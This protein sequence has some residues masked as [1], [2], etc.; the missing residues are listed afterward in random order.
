MIK[1]KTKTIK[2]KIE[3][4]VICDV[5]KKE[6][7]CKTDW[8]EVQEFHCI[9]IRGGYGSVFGDGVKWK[10]DICQHCFEKMIKDYMVLDEEED[11]GKDCPDYEP[12][13]E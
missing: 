6:F 5:C 9:R 1:Y 4:K 12:T 2:Q 13:K 8:E 3:D 11:D 10:V 7:D